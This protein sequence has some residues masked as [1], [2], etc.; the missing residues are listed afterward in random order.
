MVW[1]PRLLQNVRP[2]PQPPADDFQ[3]RLST[4]TVHEPLFAD[5]C[6][7]NIPAEKVIQGSKDL[8]SAARENFGLSINTEKTVVMHQPLPHTAHTAPQLSVNGAQL[9]LSCNTK[10]NDEVACR[11]SKA[12]KG[13]SLLKNTTW[14]RHGCH[15]VYG[16]VSADSSRQG[17]QIRRLKDTLRTS[18]SVFKSTRSTGKTSPLTDR[19]G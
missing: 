17:G 8:F 1:D 6:V 5:D 2:A 11:I 18:S 7:L 13:F 15:L 14:Y 12:S 19:L 4:A 9:T 10:I 16:D 3:S